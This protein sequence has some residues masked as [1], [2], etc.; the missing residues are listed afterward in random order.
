MVVNIDA[1]NSLSDKNKKILTDAVDAGYSALFKAYSASIDKY[2]PVAEKQGIKKI[3]YTSGELDAF[4]KAA[5][6]PVWDQWI[7]EANAVGL[8]AQELLDLV[9]KTAKEASK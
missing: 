5:A 9:L 1:Y 4:R 7:K 6:Q 8:P 2:T 3:T